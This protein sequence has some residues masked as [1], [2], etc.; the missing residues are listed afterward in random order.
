MKDIFLASREEL[1]SVGEWLLF[2]PWLGQLSESIPASLLW[3]LLTPAASLHLLMTTQ[4]IIPNDQ[5]KR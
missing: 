4:G 5:P 2:P 1:E 3:L